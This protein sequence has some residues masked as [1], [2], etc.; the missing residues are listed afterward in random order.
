M[1]VRVATARRCPAQCL[2]TPRNT[3]GIDPQL[4]LGR[5]EARFMVPT[6]RVWRGVLS[7]PR[8]PR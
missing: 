1:H 6:C 3:T 4:R 2:K 7:V 8:S 5:T